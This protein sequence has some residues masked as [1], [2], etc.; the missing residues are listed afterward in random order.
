MLYTVDCVSCSIPRY[1]PSGSGG[2]YQMVGIS[3]C[4]LML[5]VLFEKVS[6]PNALEIVRDLNTYSS[7]VQI[8]V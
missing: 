3:Q 8:P 4:I 6:V 2:H 1:S 7:S 5:A